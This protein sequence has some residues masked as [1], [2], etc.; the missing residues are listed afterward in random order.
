VE[1]TLPS[2]RSGQALSAAFDI[3]IAV[4]LVLDLT[5]IPTAASTTVKEQCFSAA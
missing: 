3:D 5:E 2:A 1:R 4:D